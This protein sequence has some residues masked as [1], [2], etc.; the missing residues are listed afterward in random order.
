VTGVLSFFFLLAALPEGQDERADEDSEQYD[1]HCAECFFLLHFI[2]L[3]F[4][5]KSSRSNLKQG[6]GYCCQQSFP[7]PA[8]SARYIYKWYVVL[9]TTGTALSDELVSLA[10]STYWHWE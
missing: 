8:S 5:K 9:Y 7:F 3:L 2:L 6:P 1:L 10:T 4:S